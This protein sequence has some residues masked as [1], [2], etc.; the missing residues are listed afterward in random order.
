MPPAREPTTPPPARARRIQRTLLAWYDAHAQ[1]FPWRD[2]RDP[3]AALVAAVCAQQTQMSR[4]LPTYERWMR[5]FPTLADAARG[6]VAQALHA[7]DRAGYPR[8]AL[9]LRATAIACMQQ[10]GGTLPRDDAA[11]RAL[12]GVGPFTAA[13]VRCFGFGEDS[14][15]IDT[16]VVRLLGRLVH[17]DLQPA[18]ET[19]RTTIEATALHLLPRGEATRWN[20]AL[21]DFG[22]AVCTPRP[23]CDACPLTAVCAAYPRFAAGATAEP[24]RTQ[25]RFEGSDRQ[26]RGRILGALREAD[27]RTADP[28]AATPRAATVSE[29]TLLATLDPA[30]DQHARLRA[31]IAALAAE[32]LAWRHRGRVGLGAQH[33]GGARLLR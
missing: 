14:A 2:A 3:Y 7:W 6:T 27:L 17:G 26:W 21:M 12:P 9:Y 30:G 25:P 11:L 29:R 20:P 32:G 13:I 28:H 23:H 33:E 10:H 1:P 18:R 5:A 31:L 16:N 15:A 19:P 4:V 8:R 22:A 24:V